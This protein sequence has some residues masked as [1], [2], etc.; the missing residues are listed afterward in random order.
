[1]KLLLKLKYTQNM[2]IYLLGFNTY[3]TQL[4]IS[5]LYKLEIPKFVLHTFSFYHV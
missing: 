3:S 5:M 4:N 1:M 2:L